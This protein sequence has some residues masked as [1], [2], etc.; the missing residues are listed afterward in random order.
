MLQRLMRLKYAIFRTPSDVQKTLHI[1]IVDMGISQAIFQL[2]ALAVFGIR[3]R[4]ARRT[5]RTGLEAAHE[6][7]LSMRDSADAV[8]TILDLLVIIVQS[9]EF[10]I[11]GRRF[12]NVRGTGQSIGLRAAVLLCCLVYIPYQHKIQIGIAI[13]IRPRARPEQNDSA[14]RISGLQIPRGLQ[15]L[16]ISPSTLNFQF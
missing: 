12:G 14:F 3:L 4:T 15:G 2:R 7:S 8:A 5:F 11:R 13:P 1:S 9:Q 6:D 16:W 10:E